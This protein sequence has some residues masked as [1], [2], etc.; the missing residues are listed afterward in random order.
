VWVTEPDAEQIELFTLAGATPKHGTGAAPKHAATIAIPGGPESL[1]IDGARG[2]AYAHLWAGKTV[3]IDVRARR[4]VATWPNG[5][6]GSRGIAL[7]GARGLLFSGCKEGRATAVD[8]NPDGNGALRGTVQAGAGID[9]IAYD[10]ARA[11]L[12]L[13][14]AT[15]ATLSIVAVSPTGAMSPLARFP[16]AQG[17]HCVAVDDRG[18]I[19]VCDPRAGRL[20]RFQDPSAPSGR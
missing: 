3:A 8:V 11:H 9:V 1:V 2:R 5:C 12:Y 4:V 16:T 6:V 17:A 13:P 20:L 7:D 19:W 18:G 14:G 15:S 10:A